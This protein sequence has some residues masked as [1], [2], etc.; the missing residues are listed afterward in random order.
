MYKTVCWMLTAACACMMFGAVISYSPTKLHAAGGTSIVATKGEPA[1]L[2]P[3]WPEGTKDLI[4]SPLR[5]TGWNSWFS[6]WPNDVHQY[7]FEFTTTAELNGLIE[8]LA[9]IKTDLHQI[10]LSY[11]KEPA[12]LGW[13]TILPKGNNIPAIFSIGNQ[14]RIDEWYK[15]V[16]KPFGQ[17]EF[18]AAPVAIPPTLTIF[19]QNDSVKL[20]DLKIPSEIE[21]SLG[22]VPRVFH[23]MNS[24]TEKDPPSQSAAEK[25][26]VEAQALDAAS[27]AAKLKIEAFIEKRSA[28]IKR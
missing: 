5:T 9:A 25:R 19:V 26:K 6:E 13:V 22:S 14:K 23:Q 15:Q 24:K 10:H 16:R 2:S 11:A 27:T 17:I 18:T 4:N 7:A 21:V 8:R 1:Y 28:A 20:D 12:A 3:S